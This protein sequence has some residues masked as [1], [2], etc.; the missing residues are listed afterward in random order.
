MTLPLS[1]RERRQEP[2][3]GHPLSG[4]PVSLYRQTGGPFDSDS[5]GRVMTSLPDP[6]LVAK[7]LPSVTWED[8]APSL[9]PETAVHRDTDLFCAGK[10]QDSVFRPV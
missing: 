5:R 4:L 1:F 8:D 10:S 6:L 9:I 2:K 3:N 7:A